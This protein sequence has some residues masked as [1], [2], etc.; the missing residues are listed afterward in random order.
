[1]ECIILAGGFGTRLRPVTFRI[2]KP[3]IPLLNRPMIMHL[4]DSLPREID[5]VVLA[6]N[7]KKEM[8]DDFFREKENLHGTGREI[9]LVEEREPLGTG[10]AIKN[11][12]PLI[13]DTFLVFNGDVIQSLDPSDLIR[14]HRT[15]GGIG[16]LA[17]WRVEDPTRYGI[18][19]FDE[20]HR[21]HRFME[22]PAPGEV[23]S[24]WINAGSYV[25]DP[26]IFDH[27]PA[28]KKVSIERE[29]YPFIT[30]RGLNAYP[31]RGFWVDA[32]TRGD[33]L[34][35]TSAIMEHRGVAI[36]MGQGNVIHPGAILLPPVLIGNNCTIEDAVIGPCAVMG[37]G[38]RIGGGS[39]IENTTLLRSVRV[40]A[41]SM[42][43]DSIIGEGYIVGE[44]SEITGSILDRE[45][46]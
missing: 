1:M 41:G 38:S 5:R 6:V 34:R 43:R 29:V 35:A 16:T 37:D 4:I 10:G 42:I 21:I 23:F 11:C 22:K 13:S 27:I 31:F 32:G 44:G 7:Y 39:I 9:R 33:F 17:V 2:P 12:E 15:R 25:L 8:L 19:G 26:E 40:G 28:G 46:G 14:F 18:I 30:E 20:D 45:T 24:N 36:S 3:I